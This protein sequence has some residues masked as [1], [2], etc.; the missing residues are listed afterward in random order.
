[1][2]NAAPVHNGALVEVWE[3][4]LKERGREHRR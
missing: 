4:H 1:M 3:S 2:G